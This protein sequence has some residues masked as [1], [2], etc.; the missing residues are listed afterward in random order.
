M[1]TD[2]TVTGI[3]SYDSSTITVV[4]QGVTVVGTYVL[5][6]NIL[7]ILAVSQFNL[8]GVYVRQ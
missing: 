2:A 6:G 1:W 7:E 3:A 5:T 8:V 4:S